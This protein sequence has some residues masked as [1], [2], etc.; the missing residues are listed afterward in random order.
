VLRG[1]DIERVVDAALR[2]T[3]KMRT[4]PEWSD[5]MAAGATTDVWITALS[6]DGA[7]LRIQQRVST[8]TNGPIA[9]EMRRRLASALT[10]ES[11]GTTRWDTP[12]RVETMAAVDPS[13]A[14][15]RAT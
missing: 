15:E 7:S 5:R 10:A 14:P 9:S 8:G 4:D 13:P 1:G 3:D 6:P 11:I 2:V 12:L